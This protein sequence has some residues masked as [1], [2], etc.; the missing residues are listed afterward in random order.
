MNTRNRVVKIYC[1][2]FNAV[3]NSISVIS[4]RP[5]RLSMLFRSSFNQ[6]SAQYS[7][8]ATGCFFH[9]TIVETVDTGEK[10]ISPVAMTITNPRKEYWPSW[11][12]NQRPSIL[13]SCTLPNDRLGYGA[14]LELVGWLVVLEFNATL[15]AKVISRRSVTHICFLAFSHQY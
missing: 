13:K 6:Y 5:V 4:L 14:R 7:F 12:S 8:Q 1:M 9:I 15:T 10:G 2:V 11:G 3:F